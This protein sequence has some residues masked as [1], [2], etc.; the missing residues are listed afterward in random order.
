METG[1]F[2]ESAGT[3]ARPRR[4]VRPAQRRAGR[5]AGVWRPGSRA[6]VTRLPRV[7]GRTDSDRYRATALPGGHRDPALPGRRDD[8]CRAHARTGC[9]WRR[10][11]RE[12]H[13]RAA[14]RT[15]GVETPEYR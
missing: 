2:L 5:C 6:V 12:T 4:P 14:A 13:V 7:R 8:T 3:V 15:A 11:K 9:E 1:C 10:D